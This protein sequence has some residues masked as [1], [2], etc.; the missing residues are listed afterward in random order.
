VAYRLKYVGRG[1]GKHRVMT[2]MELMARLAA[3]IA[4]PR[5][6]L[7]RYSGVLA[8]RSSWRRDVVRKPREPSSACDEAARAVSASNTAELAGA[9]ASDAHAHAGVQFER[10]A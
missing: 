4:P 6:P 9:P 2:P 8:P 3:I 10:G 5:Y 7:V 1:G